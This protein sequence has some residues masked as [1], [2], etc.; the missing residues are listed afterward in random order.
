MEPLEPDPLP[1]SAR[2]SLHQIHQNLPSIS[3]K[4]FPQLHIRYHPFLIYLLVG[5]F[6]PGLAAVGVAHL[7]RA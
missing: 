3:S 7:R 5:L 6:A 4:S 1:S 2:P